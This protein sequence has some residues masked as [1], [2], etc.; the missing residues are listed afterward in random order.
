MAATSSTACLI[1]AFKLSLPA[2]A[3]VLIFGIFFWDSVILSL[4]LMHPA[5]LGMAI[6]A[7]LAGLAWY[8]ML[9]VYGHSC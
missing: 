7:L 6:F 4:M 2:Y 3:G 9:W 8:A 5:P 1:K